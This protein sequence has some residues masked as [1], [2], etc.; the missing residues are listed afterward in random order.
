MGA[1]DRLVHLIECLG[2]ELTFD[3]RLDFLNDFIVDRDELCRLSNRSPELLYNVK[4]VNHSIRVLAECLW[5]V[6]EQFKD[7][8]EGFGNL[9]L[10]ALV[11][12]ELCLYPI[13]QSILFSAK[14]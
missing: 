12:T 11:W 6:F 7:F 4:G 13:D 8:F 10:Q 9:V 14:Q 5:L 2:A 1:L 3:Y